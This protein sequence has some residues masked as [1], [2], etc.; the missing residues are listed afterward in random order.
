MAYVRHTP[1]GSDQATGPRSHLLPGKLLDGQNP[2]LPDLERLH[3]AE[4]MKLSGPVQTS[5]P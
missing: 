4:F 1:Q 5:L 2:T 3:L